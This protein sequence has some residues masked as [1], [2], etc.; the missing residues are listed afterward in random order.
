MLVRGVWGG[1][2]PA[3]K[4]FSGIKFEWVNF[5]KNCYYVLHTWKSYSAVQVCSVLFF[6][7]L[8]FALIIMFRGDRDLFKICVSWSKSNCCVA[9]KPAFMIS[10]LHLNYT[11]FDSQEIE[12]FSVIQ[13][14]IL[15]CLL[16]ILFKLSWSTKAQK[17]G[18]EW[19][20]QLCFLFY[21]H[22]KEAVKCQCTKY[23]LQFHLALYI[24][25][26]TGKRLASFLKLPP[27]ILVFTFQVIFCFLLHHITISHIHPLELLKTLFHFFLKHK[28]FIPNSSSKRQNS[29]IALC[30]A[31]FPLYI[32]V[33][34][35]VSVPLGGA[36]PG[37]QC[38]ED[39]GYAQCGRQA[40]GIKPA[41]AEPQC[42][43][44]SLTAEAEWWK[45]YIYMYHVTVLPGCSLPLVLDSFAKKKK[46][47][48]GTL[49]IRQKGFFSCHWTVS[50]T[51]I[52]KFGCLYW[53]HE[54][55]EAK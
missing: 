20:L 55:P 44:P 23:F 37:H 31:D 42:C 39:S 27:S 2:Y 33:T 48:L 32:F 1:Y 5:Y 49:L 29:D 52:L 41:H 28:S 19:S 6:F 9:W 54:V 38:Q 24:F 46:K 26:S 47:T 11:W 7:F 4:P 45:K 18:G 21:P 43:Q 34:T 40:P 3:V 17:F 22:F 50:V 16:D 36:G 30:W 10:G 53:Y 15:S 35:G 14:R 13:T 25:F 12:I 51:A 8:T